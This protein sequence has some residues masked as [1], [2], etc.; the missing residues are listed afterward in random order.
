MEKTKPKK[1]SRSTWLF[2]VIF[3]IGAAVMLYPSI[4]NLWNAHLQ[5]IVK[6]NYEREVEEM[7]KEDDTLYEYEYER[8]KAYNDEL[9]PTPVL[10]DPV[11]FVGGETAP[12][13]QECLNLTGN[14]LMGFVSI[15]KIDI[16]IPIYHSTDEETLQNGAG[17][18]EGTSLPIGG[19][20]THSVIAAHRG[21]P[22]SMLFTDLDQMEI[23]DH[24]L[25]YVLDR[26]LCYEVDQIKEVDPSDNSDLAI[27]GGKDQC[28]LL[29][30]TP[31][32]VNTERLLVRGHRVPYDESE[33]E[34]A[35]TVFGIPRQYIGL[36][37]GLAAVL[38]AVLIM[39]ASGRRRHKRSK[40]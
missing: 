36:I 1:R 3:F 31:Y 40:A 10:S 35:D 33:M 23:G 34:E 20:S 12:E 27:E 11:Y 26:T 19:E 15:P 14:G 2:V 13:Y 7:G 4:S 22:G 32:G 17:H 6:S 37:I 39:V 5:D 30:C 38:I 28:T 9:W 21:L 24:F 18:L 25:L 8:A 16:E 29:T